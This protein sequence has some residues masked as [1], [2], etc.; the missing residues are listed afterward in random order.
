MM[1]I[2]TELLLRSGVSDSVQNPTPYCVQARD[3]PEDHFGKGQNLAAAV[4]F[5]S[6]KKEYRT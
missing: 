5:V 3:S 1:M 6:F 2:L 4:Q